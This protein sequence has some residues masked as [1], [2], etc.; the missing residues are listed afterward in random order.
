LFP[1]IQL[2]RKSEAF[3]VFFATYGFRFP[4]IQL[5]R[6]SEAK[7]MLH[8]TPK[9][10]TVS[11]NSTSEEVRS[12]HHKVMVEAALKFPL[13]QLPRKSEVQFILSKADLHKFPLIQLPRKSEV[14]ACFVQMGR[15]PAFPLIQLPRKSE[16]RT[17]CIL[18]RSSIWS[19]H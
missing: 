11:I 3:S 15:C 4:L 12:R 7:D 16:A 14:I 8:W 13:I 17:G 1:L 6:K 5:P 18:P 19:F 2:P 10:L 9:I